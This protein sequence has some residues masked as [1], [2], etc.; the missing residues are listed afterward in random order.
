VLA[1]IFWH[2]PGPAVDHAV[3]EA[4]LAG[5]HELLRQQALAGF[6]GCLCLRIEGAPW[7]PAR[8]AY[9][10]WYLV[11]GS[12]VLDPLNEL[13]VSAE[14]RAAHDRPALAARFGAGG[15][16][17]LLSGPADRPA[18]WATWLS[19]PFGIAYAD[20]YAELTPWTSGP[21]VSLWR[22]QMVLGPSPEFCILG[23]E[24]ARVPAQ[25]QP[26]QV[27]RYQIV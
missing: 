1:Y 16:Y 14:L 25:M 18:P 9:E 4:D 21:D 7:V 11:E 24:P 22:R 6:L 20:F 17:R 13:A 8:P 15:L 12:A 10:D 26:V 3:Y 27:R 2:A 5:F 19:K 23:P